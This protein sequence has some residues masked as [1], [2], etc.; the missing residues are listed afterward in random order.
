MA[1]YKR[2]VEDIPLRNV[3][4]YSPIIV[5]VVRISDDEIVQEVRLDYAKTEDRKHLGRLTFW[6]IQNHHMI[7]TM[8]LRDVEPPTIR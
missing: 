6:A 5:F 4:N 2:G 1:E 3:N 7:E 8:A